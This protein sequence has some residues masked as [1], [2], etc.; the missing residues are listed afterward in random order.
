MHRFIDHLRGSASTFFRGQD[1][2][3]PGLAEEVLPPQALG[4]S[5]DLG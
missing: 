4:T 5:R 1:K 2:E 3:R